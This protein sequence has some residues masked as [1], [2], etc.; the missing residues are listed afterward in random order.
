MK[1]PYYTLLIRGALRY[2]KWEAVVCS[3]TDMDFGMCSPQK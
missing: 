2:G 1:I 3:I